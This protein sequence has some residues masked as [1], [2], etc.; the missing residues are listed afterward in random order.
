M[1]D[2]DIFERYSNIKFDENPSNGSRVT[3]A[4]GQADAQTDMTKLKV[5]FCRFTN[6]PRNE[7]VSDGLHARTQCITELDDVLCQCVR[8][9]T[10]LKLK[11]PENVQVMLVM[12]C[13]IRLIV[14]RLGG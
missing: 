12:N 1:N 8:Y 3:C 11:V 7:V 2:N 4:D 6:A 9:V 14:I 13:N 5:A 10:A